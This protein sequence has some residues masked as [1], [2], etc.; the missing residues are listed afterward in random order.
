VVRFQAYA[1]IVLLTDAQAT[2]EPRAINVQSIIQ[3]LGP[4]AAPPAH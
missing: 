3:R 2:K 4:A 1:E